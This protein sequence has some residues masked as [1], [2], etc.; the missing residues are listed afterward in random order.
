MENEQEKKQ[1]YAEVTSGPVRAAIWKN[2]TK[3]GPRYSFSLSRTY[4]NEDNHPRFSRSFEPE[5]IS[6]I[7]MCASLACMKIQNLN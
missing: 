1:P 6:S 2:E 4:R 5:H 7:F 3:E